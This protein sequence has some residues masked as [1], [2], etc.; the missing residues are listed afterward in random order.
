MKAKFVRS[1]RTG[2]FYIEVQYPSLDILH[3]WDGIIA[4]CAKTL[5]N[6]ELRQVWIDCKEQLATINTDDVPL[7]FNEMLNELTQAILDRGLYL[8]IPLKNASFKEA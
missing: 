3:L 7:S 5:S 6:N 1:T 2:Q 4:H 8:K